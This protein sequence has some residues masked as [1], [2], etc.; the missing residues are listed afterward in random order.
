[1][2]R[3]SSLAA[4]G[5]TKIGNVGTMVLLRSCAQ[6]L[7][8]WRSGALALWRLALGAW[9]LALG[10]WRLALGAWRLA[11]GAWRLALEY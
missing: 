11:L 6:V 8:L 3:V 4:L 5:D 1:M 10:V 2:A 9:R 7:W